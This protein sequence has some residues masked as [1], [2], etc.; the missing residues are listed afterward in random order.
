[1]FLR[2]ETEGKVFWTT[3]SEIKMRQY[4]FSAKRV[5]RILRKPDRKE[6]GILEGTIA[7]MQKTG[8]KK[9]PTEAWAMYIIL[10]KPKGIKMIS[11]WRYPGI[12][13]VGKMPI[14]PEDTLEE[15]EKLLK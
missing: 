9:H 14:I 3:H 6:E 2:F 1:M 13:P 15:I 12:T 11:A 8:T 5:L 7:V 4:R 10:K